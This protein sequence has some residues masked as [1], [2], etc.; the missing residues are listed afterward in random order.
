[1]HKMPKTFKEALAI[2]AR[3]GTMYWRDAINKEMKNVFPAFKILDEGVGKPVGYEPIPCHMVF[4]VKM[5]FTRKARFVAAGC[6]TEPPAS[7]TYASV[8]S[9]ESVRIAFLLASLNDLDILSA[10]VVGAYLNAPCREKVFTVCG[11]EFGPEYEGRY[12]IIV[13]ALYG[14]KSASASWRSHLAH[15]LEHELEFQSCL[16]DPDVWI[17]PAVKADGEQYYEY[18]LVYTDDLLAISLKPRAILDVIDAHFKLKPDSIGKPTRYLG[19]TISQHYLPDDPTKPRWASGPDQYVKEALANVEAWLADRDAKLKSKAPSVLPSGYRPELDVSEL[20]PDEEASWYASQIGVL[21][22]A[23]ELGRIDICGEVSMMASF[24][25]AP[26]KGHLEALLHMFAYIKAHKRSKI[27]FDD[28]QPEFSN[29]FQ[30]SPDWVDFYKDAK[31]LIPPNAPEARGRSVKMTC[32]CDADH[33]S[34]R[35]TRKSRTG[36]LI[37][38]NRAPIVWYSKRQN[39]VETSCFGSEFMALKTATELCQGLRYKLRMMGVPIDGPV[40]MLC[41]NQSVIYNTTRPESTLKKKSC[42]VAYHFVRENVAARVVRIAYEPSETNLADCL[43]KI[44]T[45]TERTRLIR[46]I[47]LW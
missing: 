40:D 3:M 36:V 26:R 31:E 20:L 11:P 46:M 22:W 37:Y 12:A 47:G 42:S 16:A 24:M 45:G 13:K 1:M 32:F 44:Q 5:D 2:D 4:D 43:T 23:V 6:F 8:V 14:L 29:D 34:D 9:R 30:E 21:R 25:A 18:L 27:V 17:R 10:D 35:L 33:A 38:L 7:I 41:D 39:S 28:S 19:A 15:V